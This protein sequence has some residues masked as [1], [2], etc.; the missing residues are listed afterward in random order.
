MGLSN[1]IFI[2]P[3]CGDSVRKFGDKI[4]DGDSVQKFGDR[5]C[6]GGKKTCGLGST[7]TCGC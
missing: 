4:C 2:V 6:D 1:L 5:I 3:L 7:I